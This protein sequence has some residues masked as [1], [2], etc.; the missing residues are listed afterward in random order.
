M[1]RFTELL[2]AEHVTQ[3]AEA[4]AL[5]QLR[6]AESGLDSKL[7]AFVDALRERYQQE[8]LYAETSRTAGTYATLALLALNTLLFATNVLVFEPRKLRRTEDKIRGLITESSNDIV[9]RLAPQPGTDQE[10]LDAAAALAPS[11]AAPL[12]SPEVA[13]V[14]LVQAALDDAEARIEERIE[15]VRR[16]VVTAITAP[17]SGAAPAGALLAAAPRVAGE[18]WRVRLQHAWSLVPPGP[19]LNRREEWPLAV[20]GIT[21]I[22]GFVGGLLAS[23]GR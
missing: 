4:A 2:H 15:R 9:T 5:T 7:V 8:A 20:L 17:S 22:G 11:T 10:Q 12:V 13:F 1:S 21:V 18:D 16:D 14:A 19:L 23:S 6:N 3:S